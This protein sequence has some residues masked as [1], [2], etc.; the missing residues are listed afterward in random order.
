MA[1]YTAVDALSVDMRWN[2]GGL[3]SGAVQSETSTEMVVNVG[4][5]FVEHLTG[6]DLV[7]NGLGQL[8]GGTITGLEEHELFQNV[9]YT[10]VRVSGFAIDAG[11]LLDWAR[12]GNNAAALQAIFGGDDTITGSNGDDY[13]T[14]LSGHDVVFGGMGSDTLIGGDGNDHLYGQSPSGGT[15]GND[16]ISGGNGSDYIQG[17]AGNDTLDGGAGSDRIYGG[18]NDDSII[19]G[20]GND[21][22]NGNRGNDT[23]SG[24]NGNDVLR[25]GQGD[26]LIHGGNGNDTISGDL[27][28]DTI[29]G[30]TG[31]DV[32]TGGAGNDV[33]QFAPGD[34]A[35]VGSNTDVITDYAHGFDHIA[36]GF[37]PVAVL[38]GSA[39]TSLAAAESSAQTLFTGHSGDHEVAA[40][41]V[42]SDTYLFFGGSG[43]DTVDS[44][45]LLQG[46]SASTINLT[47]FV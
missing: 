27:G 15:D 9:D 45:V 7:Y 37:T 11:Q 29:S 25:G 14:G 6:T 32:L 41:Q 43:G 46:V 47:D 5:G 35:I 16:S 4:G 21:T 44:A 28:N 26:D 8:V 42:G 19:G 39:Q 30:D 18:A 36:L 17:N 2:L 20:D 33:F 3:A 13:L 24:D 31:I 23:I 34:A 40:L 10:D 12:T 38:T 22:I 1:R